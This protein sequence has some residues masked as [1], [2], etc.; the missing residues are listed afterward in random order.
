MLFHKLYTTLHCDT[1]QGLIQGVTS[2]QPLA[3]F[4]PVGQILQNYSMLSSLVY[5]ASQANTL[6]PPTHSTTIAMLFEIQAVHPLQF[7]SASVP[8]V[9]PLTT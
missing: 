2:H 7:I 1:V 8:A 9:L 4:I 5:H 3:G 6:S